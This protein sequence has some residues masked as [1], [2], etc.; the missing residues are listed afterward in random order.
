MSCTM[1]VYIQL[2]RNPC[3]AFLDS[4]SEVY[5]GFVVPRACRTCLPTKKHEMEQKSK[6]WQEE[7]CLELCSSLD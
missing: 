6:T 4:R 5:D 3:M 2:S 1:L 7:R